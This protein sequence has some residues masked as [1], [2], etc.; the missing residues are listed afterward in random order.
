MPSGEQATDVTLSVWSR[1]GS[2]TWA[3]VST[4]HHPTPTAKPDTINAL[5]CENI[6][7]VTYRCPRI[8]LPIGAWL[9]TLHSRIV[10]SFEPEAILVPS[11]EIATEV[12]IA[13][14]PSSGVPIIALVFTFHIFT[15]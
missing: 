11:G 6:T 5:S 14:C 4:F 12:T 8:N 9:F 15:V 10:L 7:D 1:S 13:S 2:P 3:P